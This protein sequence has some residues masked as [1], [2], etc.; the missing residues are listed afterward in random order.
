MQAGASIPRAA[1]ASGPLED[2]E[3]TSPGC[4][5]TCPPIPFETTGTQPLQSLQMASTRCKRADAS[6]VFTWTPLLDGPLHELHAADDVASLQTPQRSFVLRHANCGGP[7]SFGNLLN[8]VSEVVPLSA[9]ATT[10]TSRSDRYEKAAGM[11]AMRNKRDGSSAAADFYR[12]FIR[13]RVLLARLLLCV[14]LAT[15]KNG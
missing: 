6:V 13:C 1:V 11:S 7:A 10:S 2:V 14:S 15:G 9:S 3:V 8:S 4:T 12:F 5:G